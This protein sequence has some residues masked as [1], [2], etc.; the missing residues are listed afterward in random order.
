MARYTGPVCR[1]CRRERMKLFLK[2]PKCDTMKCPI[3]RQALPAGSARSGS[4]PRERVPAPAAREAEGPPHLRRAREAVPQHLRRGRRPEGHHRREPAAHARAAPRQRRVPR[5]LRR[6]P[7]PGPPVRAPRPRARER[8]A[9]HDPVVPGAQGR[10][11]RD[12]AQGAEDDRPAPQPRHARPGRAAVARR[13]GRRLQGGRC[14]TSRCGS[15]STCPCASSS[16]SSSTPSN[17]R[18]LRPRRPRTGRPDHQ[19]RGDAPMLIIQR[20]QVEAGE[21]E[22]NRQRFTSARSSPASATRSATASA[23]RCCRRSPAPP[24]PRCASTRRS[25]SSTSSPG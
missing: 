19:I 7:Q 3:E 24:S 10:R 14:A 15:R 18:P 1:L 22:G 23:A 13:H 16:S 20:P 5:R 4:H 21:A 11:G 6:E 12:G 9:G 2:G 17:P 8:Q 25:T